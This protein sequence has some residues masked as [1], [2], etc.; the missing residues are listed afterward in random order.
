MRNI[1]IGAGPAGI[2][3]GYFFEKSGEEY[4]ILEGSES[5]GNFFSKYPKQRKLISINKKNVFPI[6]ENSLRHDWN[7]LIN[8]ER[9]YLKSEDYYPNADDY[10]EYLSE[11]SKKFN[12]KIK[13]S[14]MIKRIDKKDDKFIL[15]DE[16]NIMYECINLFIGTGVSPKKQPKEIYDKVRELYPN[17]KVI[18]YSNMPLD[19]EM[20]KKKSV[21][22][23]GAGNA[24]LET[25]NYLNKVT[26][27]I[28]IF[29]YAKSAWQTHYP[30][31]I[32]SINLGFLDTFFLK[33]GNS[34]WTEKRIEN[35]DSMLY[36]KIL[37]DV[38]LKILEEM[39]NAS[40]SKLSYIIFCTGFEPNYSMF[41]FSFK[42]KAGNFPVLNSKFE[43]V[44]V[45]NLYFIGTMMQEN[46]YKLGTSS[47]IH[48]FRYNIEFLFRCL[49]N[50]IKAIEINGREELIKYI[51][52][53]FNKTT[54]LY[55]RLGGFKDIIQKKSENK[56]V[57]YEDIY[58]DYGNSF[59]L[60]KKITSIEINIE[61]GKEKFEQI[62]DRSTL[63]STAT[64]KSP[65]FT[66][67][68]YRI[69]SSER[70]CKKVID[71]SETPTSDLNVPSI[72]YIYIP[73]IVNMAINELSQESIL[74]FE[75]KI[76]EKIYK[77]YR[78]ITPK[79]YNITPKEYYIPETF[80]LNK[81]NN[82]VKE[83][84]RG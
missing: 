25:A 41:N 78:E 1:I 51:E 16:N 81:I 48:G 79:E 4:I 38:H 9:F 29:G 50:E 23:I 2:Q 66:H 13:L 56:F 52:N 31:N 40:G 63:F 64:M 82:V 36:V 45:K 54:A 65:P 26:E 39:L 5:V 22:I 7:S 12:L 75:K 55:H 20:Y 34:I 6:H 47:F 80:Y 28:N 37:M 21:A 10:V 60:D 83:M 30:G 49:K 15:E 46:D 61:Y 74:D 33:Q 14:T 18:E 76:I 11:F 8:S 62:T 35:G 17:C 57:Y 58:R 53:R 59:I 32:R 71:G 67:A 69:Y 44:D 84:E 73:F 3:L 19:L 43:S 72:H 42:L 77:F 68:K 70:K 27:S 24:A